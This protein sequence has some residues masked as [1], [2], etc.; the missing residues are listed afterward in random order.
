MTSSSGAFST[1]RSCTGRLES[2]R[3]TVALTESCGTCST[4]VTLSCVTTLPSGARL[5]ASTGWFRRSTTRFSG[6]TR[7]TRAS[8]PPSYDNW[9]LSMTMTRGHSA[10]T[11]S[12]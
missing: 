11:S 4:A 2:A 1:V 8:R 3:L 6:R 5:A 10:A 12:M 9:P 7:C